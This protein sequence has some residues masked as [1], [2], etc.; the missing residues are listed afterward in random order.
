M[1]HQWHVGLA[2]LCVGFFVGCTG[3]VYPLLTEK[4]LLKDS[5]LSGHWMVEIPAKNGTVSKVPVELA[6]YEVSTYD[7]TVSQEWIE[8]SKQGRNAGNTFPEDWTFKIGKID[9][10]LYGQ[11]VPR[12]ELSG[13]PTIKG[14]PVYWFGK[15]ALEKDTLR[16]YPVINRAGEVATKEDLPHIQ[17]EPSVF[18][19]LT[20][21]TMPTAQLQQAVAKHGDKL[22]EPKP[23]VMRKVEKLENRPG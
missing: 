5:D 3:S 1:N 4:D 19:E 12:E 22:F 9:N 7:L 6:R 8:S 18:A 2:V 16:Y 10:Q 11:L 17:M 13:L 21:F 14:I 20:V 15:L 23:I